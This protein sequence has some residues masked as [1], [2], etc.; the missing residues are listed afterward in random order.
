MTAGILKLV[1]SK[2]VHQVYWSFHYLLSLA[3]ILDHLPLQSSLLSIINR[4]KLILQEGIFS[5]RPLHE[6]S[7]RGTANISTSWLSFLSFE[8]LSES[9]AKPKPWERQSNWRFSSQKLL[10]N[11][12]LSLIIFL[13]YVSPWNVYRSKMKSRSLAG[14]VAVG[15]F[16]LAFVFVVLA[17]F[18]ASWL[19][20]DYR[21]LGESDFVFS[22]IH[23]ATSSVAF[24]WQLVWET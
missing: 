24:W 11:N 3:F 1:L 17:F 18:S 15:I 7:L 21:I 22:W 19:V 23:A 12:L 16:V 4:F 14:N 5:L 6:A 20:S 8:T 10:E 13:C 9:R 2:V